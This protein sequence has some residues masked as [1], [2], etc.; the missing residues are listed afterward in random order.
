MACCKKFVR[1]GRWAGDGEKPGGGVVCVI[2]NA[3]EGHSDRHEKIG[4]LGQNGVFILGVC[5]WLSIT[6]TRH[7][8]YPSICF[9]SRNVHFAAQASFLRNLICNKVIV[10]KSKSV[11]VRS[12]HAILQFPFAR[13]QTIRCRPEG[14][15]SPGAPPRIAGLRRG[16]GQPGEGR[17]GSRTARGGPPASPPE[18]GGSTAGQGGGGRRCAS[19]AA[20]KR[21]AGRHRTDSI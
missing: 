6:P 8:S 3:Q 4:V 14:R 12:T 18:P 15:H 10:F 2:K 16:L 1:T 19:G 7:T 9:F 20:R 13:I 21:T 11:R 17:G 5:L